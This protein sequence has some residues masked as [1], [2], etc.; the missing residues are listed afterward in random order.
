MNAVQV[1][2]KKADFASL[3]SGDCGF[4]QMLIPFLTPVR[5]G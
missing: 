4:A 1:D 2:K 5:L 3:N